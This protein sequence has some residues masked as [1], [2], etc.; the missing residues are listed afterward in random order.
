MHGDLFQ[1]TGLVLQDLLAVP[2]CSQ[3]H[4]HLGN[5]YAAEALCMLG[6]PAEAAEHLN[7]SIN[8][9]AVAERVGLLSPRPPLPSRTLKQARTTPDG[10]SAL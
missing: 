10:I 1:L 6:R 4:R 7:S 5:C 2:G 9:E 3:T 8:D